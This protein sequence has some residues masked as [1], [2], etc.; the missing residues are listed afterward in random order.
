MWHCAVRRSANASND[1]GWNIFLH[2]TVH[3]AV[4]YQQPSVIH[5]V[6]SENEVLEVEVRER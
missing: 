2:E 3:T 5:T 1:D 6:I 4:T